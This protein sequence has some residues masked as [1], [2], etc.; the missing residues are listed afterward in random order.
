MLA[1]RL[2]RSTL[3]KLVPRRRMTSQMMALAQESLKSSLLLGRQGTLLL[4]NRRQESHRLTP[5]RNHDPLSGLSGFDVPRQVLVDFPQADSLLSGVLHA[6]DCSTSY[7]GN[8]DLP[9][10]RPQLDGRP[11]SLNGRGFLLSQKGFPLNERPFLPDGRPF[12][13]NGRG[14]LFSRKGLPL[15]ER[16]FLLDGRPFSL[17]ERGFLFSQ[18]GSPLN[19]RPFWLDGRPFSLNRR[20]FLF[21]QKGL[22]LN[23]KR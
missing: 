2:I 21:D 20:G 12:P 17:N 18:K 6:A 13:L 10:G 1:S 4:G 7:I 14:F 15:N 11:F 19:E 9:S 22:S 3:M 16:P 5:A 23:R 8:A